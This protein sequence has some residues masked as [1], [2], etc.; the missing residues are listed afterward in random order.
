MTDKIEIEEQKKR[1]NEAH[2][3]S[4][5]VSL[6][7]KEREAMSFY[8]ANK[9]ELESY[10]EIKKM[11]DKEKAVI[12]AE[13]TRLEATAIEAPYINKSDIINSICENTSYAR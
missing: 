2:I 9:I 10:R 3:K 5:C 11:L 13:L 7:R 6:K 4:K 1:E 8:V 12:K